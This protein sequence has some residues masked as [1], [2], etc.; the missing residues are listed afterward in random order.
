MNGMPSEFDKWH[1]VKP[2]RAQVVA[3]AQAGKTDREIARALG[4]TKNT[5]I[6]HRH[7]AGLR[8]NVDPNSHTS[9]YMATAKREPEPMTLFDRMAALEARLSAVLAECAALKAKTPA[10]TGATAGASR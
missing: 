2:I 5:I 6:G 8:A 7:R 10:A 1:T 4:I 3:L 9:V